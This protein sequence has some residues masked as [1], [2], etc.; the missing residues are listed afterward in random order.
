MTTTE[1]SG[2]PLP[3]LL[4]TGDPSAARLALAVARKVRRN[5]ATV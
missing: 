3:D 1:Y 2:G 5:P 4:K